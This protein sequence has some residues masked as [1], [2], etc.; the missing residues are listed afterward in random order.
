MFCALL[1]L[2]SH[3]I[4]A[5]RPLAQ[6]TQRHNSTYAGLVHSADWMTKSISIFR[7]LH[8]TVIADRFGEFPYILATFQ[9]IRV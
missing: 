7:K 1:I 6:S 9:C 2:I 5:L 8:E 3:G 4:V